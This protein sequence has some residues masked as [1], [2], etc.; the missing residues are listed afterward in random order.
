[1]K[2]NLKLE[3]PTRA[4][5]TELNK[6][7]NEIPSTSDIDNSNYIE[8]KNTADRLN[9]STEDVI[10][11]VR[12]IDESEFTLRELISQ[13]NKSATTFGH[14]RSQATKIPNINDQ[15]NERQDKLD[16]IQY[17]TEY[18]EE[19]KQHRVK[20]IK[21]KIKEYK[22][23]RDGYQE[24]INNFKYALKDQVIFI[25]STISKLLD[26]G[27][28]IRLLFLEQGITVFSNIYSICYGIR[29]ISR[30]INTKWKTRIYNNTFKYYRSGW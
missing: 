15:I 24:N 1:M 26:S 6:I 3:I 28:K 21:D 10:N 22:E 18:N 8:L 4:Q 25:K 11:M 9:K 30:S 13:A 5:A 17:S 19:E 2:N 27:G 20:E 12:E 29:Y 7:N 23:I 16:Y 14:I